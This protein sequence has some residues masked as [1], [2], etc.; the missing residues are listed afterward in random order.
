MNDSSNVYQ[1]AY[2]E[3]PSVQGLG[4][5]SLVCGVLGFCIPI[6]SSLIGLILGIVAL[7]KAK[8]AS[9][10]RTLAIAGTIISASS[11]L[12][13][14]VMIGIMLPALG[15]ARQA[16]R[17]IKSTTQMRLIAQSL[18]IY[19]QDYNGAFPEPGTD[20]T[21]R[22]SGVV[23]PGDFIS[24]AEIYDRSNSYFYLGGYTTKDHF[25]TVI[26]VEDPNNFRWRGT[27]VAFLD[28]SIEFVTEPELSK[29]LDNA[30][31]AAGNPLV[32]PEKQK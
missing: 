13:T 17:Q 12:I 16:A 29:L 8:P 30:K 7:V 26:L 22:L 25:R 11:I 2:E 14:P 18:T 4:I 1:Q 5:G 27:N 20:L 10:G 31:D 3:A 23:Q 32:L 21:Q 9:R 28:G 24:P 6:V 19:A 15:K